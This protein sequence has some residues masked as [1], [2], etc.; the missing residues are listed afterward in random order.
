MWVPWSPFFHCVCVSC[1]GRASTRAEWCPICV[2]VYFKGLVWNHIENFV[3]VLFAPHISFGAPIEDLSTSTFGI[4]IIGRQTIG[5]RLSTI[6]CKLQ[7][8]I[9]KSQQPY[10]LQCGHVCRIA[11]P[12]VVSHTY[13]PSQWLQLI[14]KLVRMYSMMQLSK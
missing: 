2:C 3:C 5:Y 1:L 14:E 10:G 13:E 12:W 6:G 7:V 8:F 9:Y 4:N 11:G